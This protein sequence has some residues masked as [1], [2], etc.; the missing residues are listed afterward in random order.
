MLTTSVDLENSRVKIKV[1]KNKPVIY[2]Y[3]YK[4][5]NSNLLGT[6]YNEEPK[7]LVF[8]SSEPI[9]FGLIDL[10]Y[11]TKIYSNSVDYH[12]LATY[13]KNEAV[14]F[15][16]SF[17]LIDN[18]LLIRF[19]NVVEHKD[20]HLINIHMPNLISIKNEDDDAKL[21]IPSYGG[22]LINLSTASCKSMNFKLDCVNP[23]L[24][25]LV[26]NSKVIGILETASLENEMINSIYEFNET[27]YASLSLNFIYRLFESEIF[28]YKIP[29]RDSKYHLL[30]QESSEALISL[31]DDYD[32]DGV[33]SWVDAAKYIRDKITGSI[34][35]L[36]NDKLI[37]KIFLDAPGLKD[38]TTFA[39][40]LELIKKIAYLT[41]FAPQIVYLVGW[42]Y[43]GHDTGYPAMDKVNE[44]LGGYKELIKL[45]KKAKKYNALVSFHDNYDD[46]YMSSPNW[47]P[48]VICRDAAGNLMMGGLWGGGQ[49]YI[50]S[51][52]KYAKK[53]GS[54]RVRETLK[55]Y[56]IRVS[57]HIDV[58]SAV[59]RR[60][61]FNPESPAEAKRNLNGKIIIVKEFNKHGIDVTSE[62][63]TS[64]FIGHISHYW[65]LLL[66]D[67]VC[68]NYEEPIP[69]I[70]F[71]YHDKAS[72][73]VEIRG[74]R[75]ILRAL[76][77]GA[78]FYYD[79]SKKTDLHYITDLYYLVTLPW[80]KLY[81]KK[82]RSYIRRGDIEKVIYE[83]GSYVEADFGAM[84]YVVSVN[85]TVISKDF[86]CFVPIKE[87]LYLGYSKDGGSFIYPISAR[88]SE[89]G[90]K[91]Y[92]QKLSADGELKEL[93]DWRLENGVL[94]F[95]AEPHTPYRIFLQDVFES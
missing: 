86:T 91:M 13:E 50:I 88:W 33:V 41:S 94:K 77:Y 87:N 38:F 78:T 6:V 90:E 85:G 47:D 58:L 51:N 23:L 12:I 55:R 67:E 3:F 5:T 24:V 11:E 56:P 95:L 44:R 60:Y 82:M 29:A 20:F 10:N 35:P 4:P 46:A 83:D 52:Y 76:I 19:Y 57:Y 15:D 64:P 18:G 34:N 62:G 14:E 48:E 7:L 1:G 21:I 80:M 74:K 49:S 37:Y 92:I 84:K 68:Y 54:Q 16:L 93:E 40:A 30:V 81:G 25:E 71:I 75:D 72:Y 36:Y 22:R 39:D 17:K 43:F 31:I 53:Y 79:V 28:W 89:R 69:F 2:E 70:P 61:D 45:I 9:W 26:C 42:Q 32:K 59:P 27:R 63:L 65:W 66:K 73:G 8:K